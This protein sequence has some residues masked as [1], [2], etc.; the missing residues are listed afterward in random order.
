[1][2]KSQSDV[3]LTCRGTSLIR[4]SILKRGTEIDDNVSFEIACNTERLQTGNS[5]IP[6][7]R[8]IEEHSWKL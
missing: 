3:I 2:E 7:G 4:V 1:M 6:Q 5:H 8:E